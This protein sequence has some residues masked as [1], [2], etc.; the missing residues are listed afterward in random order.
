MERHFPSEASFL[1]R[2]VKM[3]FFLN[4]NKAI[5][6]AMVYTAVQNG[7]IRRLYFWAGFFAEVFYDR[8]GS[9]WQ[10]PKASDAS[11]HI[12][13]IDSEPLLVSPSNFRQDGALLD[14]KSGAHVRLSTM[15][16]HLCSITATGHTHICPS[17]ACNPTTGSSKQTSTTTA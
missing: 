12:I 10:E 6:I 13:H 16:A 1:K 5:H 11:E 3:K 9:Q 14:A 15:S 8:D 7:H 17:I 4:A 2:L